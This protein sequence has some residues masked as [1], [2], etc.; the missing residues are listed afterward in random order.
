MEF[1]TRSGKIIAD[2]NVLFIR[3]IDLSWHNTLA[4]EVFFPLGWL[5]LFISRFFGENKSSFEI[6]VTCLIG[7][8]MMMHIKPLYDIIFR[9][10]LAYRIP[11]NRIASYEIRE[12]N[13]ILETVVHL[14]LHTGR[15]RRIVFRSHEG[16]VEPFTRYLEQ[17]LIQV[18][19]A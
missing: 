14:N 19:T 4:Y 3:M 15:Y 6:A 16:Q 1:I 9:R 11:V 18:Q 12:G 2:K 7:M 10:S 8:L 17:F 13:N 5:L